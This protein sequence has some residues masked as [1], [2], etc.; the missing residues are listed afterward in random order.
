MEITP[1]KEKPRIRQAG[2]AEAFLDSTATGRERTYY[3]HLSEKSQCIFQIFNHLLANYLHDFPKNSSKYSKLVHPNFH[4]P[5][6][7]PRPPTILAPNSL[8]LGKALSP[9]APQQ[10]GT[11]VSPRPLSPPHPA[12]RT[13]SSDLASFRAQVA[14]WARRIRVKPRHVRLQAMPRKWASCST[15]GAVSFSLDFLAQPA[16]FREYVIV[17]ELLHL[18][19]PDH[20]RLFKSLLRSYLPD[21]DSSRPSLTAPPARLSEKGR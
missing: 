15:A 18:R 17:H 8:S 1:E 5:A 2:S 21:D 19:V 7:I 4:K 3:L 12:R 10:S 6:E 16:Q 20:G 14:H 11:V 13:W 9:R